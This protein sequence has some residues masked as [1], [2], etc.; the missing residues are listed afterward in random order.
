MPVKLKG[1]P[2]AEGRGGSIWLPL[3]CC[4]RACCA[5]GRRCARLGRFLFPYW[6]ISA[7]Y[8]LSLSPSSSP[9]P[10]QR[11][12][13]P[14]PAAPRPQPSL[15]LAL[16]ASRVPL[17]GPSSPSLPA[18]RRRRRL[19]R[20]VLLR[21]VECWAPTQRTALQFAVWRRPTSLPLSATTHVPTHALARRWGPEGARLSAFGKWDLFLHLF[22]CQVAI[23]GLGNG[24]PCQR[25]D[26][27]SYFT[28]SC[29][30]FL[31][32]FE[33]ALLIKGLQGPR[34]MHSIK[35]ILKVLHFT[36]VNSQDLAHVYITWRN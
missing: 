24:Q 33:V 13:V 34:K 30:H 9:S 25:P 4:L 36:H 35:L 22:Q 29:G 11:E 17:P 15:S 1:M 21:T 12:S 5:R 28:I 26:A 2:S 18:G 10:F 6:Y 16:S 14:L 31:R 8:H 20:R 7:L 32:R 23:S 27:C 3:R 19:R